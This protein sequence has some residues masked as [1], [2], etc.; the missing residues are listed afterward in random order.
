MRTVLLLCIL[1]MV[2]SLFPPP[3]FAELPIPDMVAVSFGAALLLGFAGDECRE[4]E[5][6]DHVIYI[7][8]HSLY[9][10][11]REQVRAWEFQSIYYWSPDY[12]AT[13]SQPQLGDLDVYVRVKH[14]IDR[15][16]LLCLSQPY[17]RVLIAAKS[18]FQAV[19]VIQD[20]VFRKVVG[21][22]PIWGLSYEW[23]F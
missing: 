16:L 20:N 21:L 9:F 2:L 15:L 12:Q 19:W 8:P 7:I 6:F 17:G 23:W 14:A 13:R 5:P 22:G 4:P 1:L 10:T 3:V 11:G 18:L